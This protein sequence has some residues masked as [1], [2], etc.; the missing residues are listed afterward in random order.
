MVNFYIGDV[1]LPEQ[2]FVRPGSEFIR[3]P[4]V[5][6]RPLIILGT[7]Q[8]TREYENEGPLCSPRSAKS[9]IS[10]FAAQLADLPLACTLGRALGEREF[11]RFGL[12]VYP[13]TRPEDGLLRVCITC[14]SEQRT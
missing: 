9:A 13:V 11:C 7:Q 12:S 3:C 14:F 6:W 1:V 10:P 2:Y 8:R 5:C 4:I